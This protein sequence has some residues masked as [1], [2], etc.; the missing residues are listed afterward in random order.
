LKVSSLWNGVGVNQ[1]LDYQNSL[2]FKQ[3][4]ELYDH[5]VI[6]RDFPSSFNGLQ[7]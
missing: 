6:L 3:I 5:L 2:N 4:I 7:T 1:K